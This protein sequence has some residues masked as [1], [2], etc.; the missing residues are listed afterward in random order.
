MSDG[1]YDP[2]ARRDTPLAR[3][4][5]RR[6]ERE[7]PLSIDAFM[8]ACLHD[9]E[10]GYYRARQAIGRAGDFVTAPEISQVFGELVGLWAAVVW[11]QMGRPDPCLLIELGPGR[12]TLLKDALRASRVVRG[13]LEALTLAL[14]ETNPVLIEQ[15][16]A[17]VGGLA[18]RATWYAH[19]AE[20]PSGP[21]IVLAN[22]FL[23]TLPITQHVRVET[24][25][26]ER[27]VTCDA[28]GDLQFTMLDAKPLRFLDHLI[29]DAKPG[30]LLE[31]RK[32][33][34]TSFALQKLAQ[35]GPVAAL[36]LDYGHWGAVAGDTLQAVRDQRYEHPLASPGEADLTSHVE[37]KCFATELA[38]WKLSVDGLVTQA[39]FLGALGIVERASRLMSANPGRAAEIEAGVARL[40]S[41]N[42]MGSRFKALGIR[43]PGLPLLPG[44]NG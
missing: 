23:D 39:E 16:R 36:F 27:G 29:G 24:G 14:V 1:R 26:Q 19:A 8:A 44:F 7:G 11:Q 32:T 40:M 34:D 21:S 42:G 6:I 20:I 31:Q 28:G 15:Q 5:K 17:V 18:T 43:S 2:T 30:V 33:M 10:H 13:F 22:E 41:P 3:K 35:G 4:L 37:F 12:G 38:T 9:P 25:W